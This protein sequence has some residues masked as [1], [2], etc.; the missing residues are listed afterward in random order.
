LKIWGKKRLEKLFQ[1]I[2]GIGINIITLIK[3]T[4][5]KFA[6]KKIREIIPKLVCNYEIIL[7]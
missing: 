4:F 5:G 2:F 7:K 6:K 3:K 1:I